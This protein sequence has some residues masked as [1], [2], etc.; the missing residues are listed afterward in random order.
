[1]ILLNRLQ[2]IGKRIKTCVVTGKSCYVQ[3]NSQMPFRVFTE[4]PDGPETLEVIR[5]SEAV[6]IID[7]I[8]FK[9]SNTEEGARLWYLF[10]MEI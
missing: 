6:N 9:S 1:M 4:K 2:S 8:S 3:S 7:L 5:G 10:K